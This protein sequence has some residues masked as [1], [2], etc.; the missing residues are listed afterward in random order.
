MISGC[1]IVKNEEKNLPRWLH[2]MKQLAD[3]IIVVDTGSSDRTREILDEAGIFYYVAAWLG[4]F[5]SAKNSALS[6]ATKKWIVFLDA[7]EYFKDEDIPKVRDMIHRADDIKEISGIACPLVNINGDKILSESMQ[8]RIFRNNNHIFYYGRV[9][10]T[11]MTDGCWLRVAPVNDFKIWHTGY[12]SDVIRQ[13][14]KR[15]LE[16][17]LDD[18][19]RRGEKWEDAFYLADCYYGLDRYEEAMKWAQKALDCGKVLAG[20]EDRPKKIILSCAIRRGLSYESRLQ[21]GE[22]VSETSDTER[23]QCGCL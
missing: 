11:L 15:N 8:T 14:C 21:S 3:E 2:C 13:K 5:S 1:C 16:I 19:A 6:R 23:I 12:A 4:D 17:L 9:H 7:D 18:I 10:E 22:V 20:F